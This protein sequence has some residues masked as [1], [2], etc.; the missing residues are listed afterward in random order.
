MFIT[1]VKVNVKMHGLKTRTVYIFD[2]TQPFEVDTGEN[3]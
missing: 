2:S 3:G 1:D